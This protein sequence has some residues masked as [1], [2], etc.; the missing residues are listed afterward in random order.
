MATITSKLT[1]DSTDLST[2]ETLGLSV[3]CAL[4]VGPPSNGISQLSVSHSAKSNILENNAVTTYVYIKNTDTTNHVKLFND[5]DN[6][7][8][9]VW[10]GQFAFFAVEDAL[11]L[12][13]QANNA[14]CVIDYAYWTKS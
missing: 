1:L 14:A 12:R 6:H 13:V 9:I 2:N 3:S 4:T 7:W 8:G 5:S 11:G 10:P